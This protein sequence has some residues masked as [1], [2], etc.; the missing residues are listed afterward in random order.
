MIYKIEYSV[1]SCHIRA[2]NA[3]ETAVRCGCDADAV[4]AVL[5]LCYEHA[6]WPNVRSVLQPIKHEYFA[7]TALLQR[8]YSALPGISTWIGIANT[9]LLLLILIEK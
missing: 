9:L 6:N 1:T 4:G 5:Q 8:S 7:L 3:D 2:G